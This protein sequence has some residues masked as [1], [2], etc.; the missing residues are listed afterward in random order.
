MGRTALLVM[1]LANVLLPAFPL[2]YDKNSKSA[3]PVIDLLQQGID[4]R[5]LPIPIVID[6]SWL[7]ALVLIASLPHSRFESLK[8]HASSL[9]PQRSTESR[10]AR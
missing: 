2:A 3:L 4:A 5:G 6:R 7:K 8:L 9:T 10:Q 1:L